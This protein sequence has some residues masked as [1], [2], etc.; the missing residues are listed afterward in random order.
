MKDGEVMFLVGIGAVALFFYGRE[1]M[2]LSD[3]KQEEFSGQI[4]GKFGVDRIPQAG[5][6]DESFTYHTAEQSTLD[7]R[8]TLFRDEDEFGNITTYRFNPNDLTAAQRR[9]LDRGFW[10]FEDGE[11][12]FG[13][14]QMV[15]RKLR[16][17]RTGVTTTIPFLEE[18]NK[19][20]TPTTTEP[21]TKTL[22]ELK[23]MQRNW[24]DYWVGTSMPTLEWISGQLGIEHTKEMRADDL[25][26]ES[27]DTYEEL[28]D[29]VTTIMDAKKAAEDLNWDLSKY[30][31]MREFL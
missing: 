19:V 7:P 25:K 4:G 3:E 20:T 14:G 16:D 29:P 2:P 9:A 24:R 28:G 31:S 6:W 10:D 8:Y 11:L 1:K 5:A 13:F 12:Q 22:A 27:F 21:K 30:P 18:E 15:E 17:R 26:N 23:E